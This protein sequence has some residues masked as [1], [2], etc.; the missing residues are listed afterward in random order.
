MLLRS[1]AQYAT[2][3]LLPFFLY[4]HQQ[5]VNMTPDNVTTITNAILATALQALFIWFHCRLL[6]GS[7]RRQA[8]DIELQADQSTIALSTAG[9]A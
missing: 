6:R 7:F 5:S 8:P 1:Q 4:F 9:G 3:A 2:R